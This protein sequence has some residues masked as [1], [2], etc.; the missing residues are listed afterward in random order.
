M[1]CHC[2]QNSDDTPPTP[3]PNPPVTPQ[4]PDPPVTPVTPDPPPPVSCPEHSHATTDQQCACDDGYVVNA[5]KTGCI[6]APSADG[7][8]AGTC[9]QLLYNACT[10][11]K[12]DPCKWAN[13]GYCDNACA[14]QTAEPFADGTDCPVPCT[15]NADCGPGL[16]CN[17][18]TCIIDGAVVPAGPVPQCTDIPDWY[19]P[20][21][22]TQCGT[23]VPFEP[24]H[25]TGYW[26]YLING[27][28]QENQYR[29]FIRR[30]TMLLIKY[31]AAKVACL[32]PNWPGNG[33]ELGLGD[34]SEGNGAIPGASINQPGHP[35]GTH[36]NGHDMDIGYYQVGTP[37]NQLR[38]ICPHAENGQEAY[39]CVGA[40]DKL[41]PWR[42]ALFIAHMH[43][44]PQLRVIGVDGK[45]GVIITAAVKQLCDAG[46]YQGPACQNLK[47]AY[48]VT[49]QG[50]GW[51]LFHHHHFHISLGNWVARPAAPAILSPRTSGPS[52]ECIVPG[53]GK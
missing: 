25:G 27:E 20:D 21:G 7:P 43:D 4:T 19:C 3:P 52:M 18:G 11:G 5:E 50:R 15:A 9:G 30:D 10:C 8:C 34:M 22:E 40:P 12:D 24:D 29:S 26:D 36:V 23:I 14:Q 13:D 33:G 49:D 46:W 48:E 42:T 53:C 1:L 41:D 32:A 2:A 47:L 37:N 28:T 51:F 31:A 16:A 39:H 17:A 35:E 38:P 6:I 44:S 45:A